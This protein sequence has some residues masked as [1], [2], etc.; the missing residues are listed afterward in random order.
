MTSGNFAVVPIDSITIDRENR[1]RR[2]LGNLSELEAS[3]R[4][5]GLINPI[6]ITRDH[7]LI[8]GERRLTSARN[9][10]LTEISVQYLEDLSRPEQEMIELEENVQRK[11]LSWQDYVTTVARLHKIKSETN[12]D[13]TQESTAALLNRTPQHVGQVLTVE[14]NMDYELVAKA[15][16]FSVARN[17]ANRR[18]ERKT[19]D[20][21]RE[22]D[23]VVSDSIGEPIPAEAANPAENAGEQESGTPIPAPSRATILNASFHDFAAGYSGRPYNLL[24][25]D[26]PYGV[27]VGDKVGQSA[28]KITGT[29][30]DTP[31]VY[32][33][34][35]KT[36]TETQDRLIMPSAHLMFWFSMDYYN[37]TKTI[38]EAAGWKVNPFPLIWHKSDNTGILPDPNRGPRR[39]YETALL[40][41]RGDRKIVRAVANSFGAPTTR[42][43]HTSEKPVSVLQHFLRMLVDESTRLL[44][45]TAGS[46]NAVRVASELGADYALGVEL[47]ADFAAAA[48]AAMRESY[49]E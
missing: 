41:S 9:I 21:L 12:P 46:G 25:C 44:D 24:H 38:L 23:R 26:F 16:S 39:T 35:L 13:W 28:A 36:L 27:G 47:D 20:G 49:L 10:G 3:I 4:Q 40:A 14:R 32:F 18:E 22:L 7:L 6:T 37:E 19:A 45:P 15:D 8:A 33:A 42:E 30:E 34:L 48:N 11:D 31:D 17:T 5:H 29:Y 1:Q 2:D 43:R